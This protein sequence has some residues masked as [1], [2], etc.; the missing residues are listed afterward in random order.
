MIIGNYSED[1][2]LFKSYRYLIP[3]PYVFIARWPLLVFFM[4][5]I[6]GAYQRRG[7]DENE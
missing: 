2:S 1:D 7:E 3:H 6:I 4:E 5:N